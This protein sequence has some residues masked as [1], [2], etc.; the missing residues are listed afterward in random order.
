MTEI[1][2]DLFVLIDNLYMRLLSNHCMYLDLE[3]VECLIRLKRNYNE[4]DNY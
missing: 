4:K 1:L 2:E 3:Q